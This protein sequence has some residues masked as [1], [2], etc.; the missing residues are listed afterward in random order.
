MKSI[1]IRNCSACGGTHR[2]I[3]VEN[4][5]HPMKVNNTTFQYITV[6]PETGI[7]IYVTDT[8]YHETLC[9]DKY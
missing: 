3:Q 9:G 8:R 2:F 5:S 4:C 1:H 6:C 7:T